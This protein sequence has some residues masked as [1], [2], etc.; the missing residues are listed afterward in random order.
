MG[1]QMGHISYNSQDVHTLI[2]LIKKTQTAGPGW[3]GRYGN[4]FSNH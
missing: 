2:C 4:V 1:N 3:L